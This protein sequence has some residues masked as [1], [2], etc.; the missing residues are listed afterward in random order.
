MLARFQRRG[1]TAQVEKEPVGL[2][3]GN[4]NGLQKKLILVMQATMLP[5]SLSVALLYLHNSPFA[6]AASMNGLGAKGKFDQ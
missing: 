2:S 1:K 5:S 3:P 6:R 4:E